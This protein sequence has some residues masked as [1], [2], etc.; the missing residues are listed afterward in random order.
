MISSAR[1]ASAGVGMTRSTGSGARVAAEG[2]V[3]QIPAERLSIW[4]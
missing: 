2:S 3:P 4:S 1:L